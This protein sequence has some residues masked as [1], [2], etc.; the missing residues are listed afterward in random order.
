MKKWRRSTTSILRNNYKM[1]MKK[2]YYLTLTHFNS[3]YLMFCC[4]ILIVF[5][6]IVLVYCLIFIYRQKTK[7]ILKSSTNTNLR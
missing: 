6:F 7:Y 5:L 2:L 3:L 4:I 1:C